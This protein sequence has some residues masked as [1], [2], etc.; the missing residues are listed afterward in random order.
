MT[1]AELVIESFGGP[2]NTARILGRSR[3]R[4]WRWTQPKSKRG[5]GGKLPADII[6]VVIEKGE[7]YGMHFTLEELHYGIKD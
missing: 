1:P 4:V 3:S 6:D 7:A 5:T 2:V